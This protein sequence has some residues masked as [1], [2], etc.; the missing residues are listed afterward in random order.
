MDQEQGLARRR[1][2]IVQE[3]VAHHRNCWGRRD[4]EEK[5]LAQEVHSMSAPV[6]AGAAWSCA[7]S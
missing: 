4:L 7:L 5:V 3:V 1:D 6:E 2:P